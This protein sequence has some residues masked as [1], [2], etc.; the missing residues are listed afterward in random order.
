MARGAR[1]PAL[2]PSCIMNGSFVRGCQRL[3]KDLTQIRFFAD[4][5][6]IE[7]M[8]TDADLANLV[9]VAEG[10][11][12]PLL[13]QLQLHKVDWGNESPPPDDQAY[14]AENKF[15]PVDDP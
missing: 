14:F 15:I 1:M 2:D 8:T 13:F 6:D 10:A 4:A 12:K 5:A 7:W 3:L 9:A 11:Y